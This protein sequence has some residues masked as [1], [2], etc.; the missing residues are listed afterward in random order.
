M[1]K[2][3]IVLIVIGLFA[4]LSYATDKDDANVLVGAVAYVTSQGKE[5]A[6]NTNEPMDYAGVN[7]RAYGNRIGEGWE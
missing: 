1:K 6:I 2:T 3:I 7:I 5:K 4:G